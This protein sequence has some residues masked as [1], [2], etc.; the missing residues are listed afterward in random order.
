MNAQRILRRLAQ[1]ALIVGTVALL[2]IVQA[3]SVPVVGALTPMTV[4]SQ[5]QFGDVPILVAPQGNPWFCFGGRCIGT[6][7]A[8]RDVDELPRSVSG[9]L[10]PDARP[11]L[12][13]P[14]CTNSNC[15]W[16]RFFG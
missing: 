16:L 2:P 3:K 14:S 12:V 10:A 8:Q 1:A 7:T 9:R 15:N 4:P 11:L 5:D 6:A 13:A